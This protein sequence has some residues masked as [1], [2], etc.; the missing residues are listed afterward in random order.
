MKVRLNTRIKGF[1]E[2]SEEVTMADLS[3]YPYVVGN[4]AYKSEKDAQRAVA[5]QERIDKLEGQMNYNNPKLVLALYT[6]ILNGNVFHTQQGILY[7]VHLQD[8]LFSVQ[9]QLGVEIPMIPEDILRSASGEMVNDGT[10]ENGQSMAGDS[11]KNGKNKDADSNA[12]EPADEE[13]QE[14]KSPSEKKQSAAIRSL[15]NQRKKLEEQL[16]IHRI[17]IGF[18]A[19]LVIAMLIIAGTGDSP[20]ILNYKKQVE[21]EYVEW[22]MKLDDMETQLKQREKEVQQREA[23]LGINN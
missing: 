22:Q 13:T 5:E 1:D 17:I 15:R 4:F 3:Q 6:K 7:L 9:K 10:T 14:K 8:Y 19:V 16:L 11:S 12:K 18:L 21:N 20:T 23:E 2:A